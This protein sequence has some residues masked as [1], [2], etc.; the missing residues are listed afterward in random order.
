MLLSQHPADRFKT[1]NIRVT[2]KTGG[3]SL[4][5]CQPPFGFAELLRQRAQPPRQQ[6]TAFV[7]THLGVSGFIRVHWQGQ[8]Y[9]MM[10]HQQRHDRADE[11]LKLP[12]GYVD[13]DH[14][15]A[16][17]RALEQEL[18]EELLL[19]TPEG[20]LPLLR[21][22][23]ALPRPYSSQLAYQSDRAILKASSEFEG[24]PILWQGE[25][26]GACECYLHRPTGSVQLVFHWDLELPDRLPRGL[27]LWQLEERLTPTGKMLETHWEYREPLWLAPLNEYDLLDG[28]LYQLR[29][30]LL[31]PA[32]GGDR[33]LLSEYFAPRQGV[34]VNSDNIRLSNY[35]PCC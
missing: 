5:P 12:S 32:E 19:Q 24:T 4:S 27:T 34:W 35:H 14:L 7:A 21:G 11:V 26:L 9:L 17:W 20:L 33:L 22:N 30:D 16:P 6:G 10:V 31:L 15:G 23:S 18:C 25:R 28:G 2:L 1:R 8:R 3:I 13:C 29:D